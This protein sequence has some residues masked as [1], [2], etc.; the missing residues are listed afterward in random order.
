VCDN[1]QL[2][3]GLEK[4]K[5]EFSGISSLD[6]MLHCTPERLFTKQTAQKRRLHI[7]EVLNSKM[8]NIILSYTGVGQKTSAGETWAPVLYRIVH[9]QLK[10]TT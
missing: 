9:C 7:I 8:I 3:S 6:D 10:L 5:N 1:V 4:N 2:I